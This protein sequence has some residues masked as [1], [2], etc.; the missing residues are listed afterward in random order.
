MTISEANAQLPS[1][2]DKVLQIDARR[3]FCRAW[4]PADEASKSRPARC[5]LPIVDPRIAP[6]VSRWGDSRLRCPL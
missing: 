3:P 5:F 6:K 2:A 1:H 4:N